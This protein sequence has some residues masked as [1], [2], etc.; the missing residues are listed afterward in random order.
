M[1]DKA[2][3][4]P[5]VPKQ[6]KSLGMTTRVL[7]ALGLGTACGLFFG[8]YTA[9]LKVLGDIYVGLLQMTV[10]PYITASLVVSIGRLSWGTGKRMMAVGGFI[11]LGLWLFGLVAV[12]LSPL[13]L[14]TW[15]TGSFFKA[16]ML[17]TPPKFD[18]IDLF[19]PLNVFASLSRNVVPAVVVFCLSLGGALIGMS[20]KNS[21]L[22]MLETLAE[23]LMRVNKAVVALTPYGVFAIAG[24]VASTMTLQE[25]SSIQGYII[26]Y[27][28]MIL[29][30][31]LVFLPL[32]ISAVTPF[33]YREILRASRSAMVTAFA[34]GKVL[35]VLPLLIDSTH[36]LFAR[37]K[38]DSVDARRSVEVM[39]PL[40][41]PFPSLGKVLTIF[42]IPFAAWFSG[43]A[44][45]IMAYPAMLVAGL[46]S[47]FGGP[48]VAIPFLLDMQRLPA[49]LFQLFIA[50]GVWTARVGD[51]LSAMHLVAM[52]V[53]TTSAMVGLM[54]ARWGAIV[55]LLV[56]SAVVVPL[57]LVGIRWYLAG[58]LEGAEDPKDTI[59][60]MELVT[61]KNGIAPKT[62]VLKE[63][64]PNPDPVLED[65][66]V[67]DRVL[68]RKVLRVGFGEDRMPF[69]YRNGNGDV[70]GFDIDVVG[71]LAVDLDVDLELVPINIDQLQDHVRLD[72]VDIVASGIQGNIRLATTMRFS[73]P[74]LDLHLAFLVPDTDVK[75]WQTVGAV[76]AQESPV[77]AVFQE[78]EFTSL[79]PRVVPGMK[80]VQL[81]E[82]R[83]FLE[84]KRPDINAALVS[85]EGA[86]FWTLA[87][88]RFRVV[89]PAGTKAEI[90][91]VIAYRFHDTRL[92]ELLDHWVS[93][94]RVD[95]TIQRYFDY[96]I[97]GQSAREN[98]PRWCVIRNVFGWVD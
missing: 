19:L 55:R 2:G 73:D 27:T 39:Y 42:F 57:S 77:V 40:A 41:Y 8:E 26:V 94:R 16:S 50:A 44:L 37:I 12:A 86:A 65:E 15:E 92:D 48:V 89:R 70:V 71:R 98:K 24:G 22:D 35:I 32:L 87:Y 10:L 20:R 66:S 60:K 88:P 38:H 96:W 11:L 45:E 29:Y 25:V 28:V 54:K 34:T 46:F 52:A 84:G 67:L 30:M 1:I 51:L 43:A 76:R 93:L 31:A 97:L 9:S 33:S 58:T 23:A 47:M 7:I 81:E 13:A 56:V 18:F 17:H 53:I 72:H 85:A 59:A 95:G 61:V 79:L 80:V 4:L 91:V 68:R 78:T 14:P 36:E 90:P 3:T 82:P 69:T 5:G 63:A 21:F 6:K 49:D 75:Q 83:D 74:Y 64:G 62:I